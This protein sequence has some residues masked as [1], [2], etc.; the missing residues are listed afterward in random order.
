[1]SEKSK[2]WERL[3]P[4][5]R[6]IL[7]SRQKVV[8][9]KLSSI[10]KDFGLTVLS[11]TL[12]VGISGEIRPS[13]DIG[14]FVIKVN[15][16]DDARRQRFTVAHEMAHFLLH[17]DYIGNGLSD[18]ALYRSYLSDAKEAQANRLAADI[19]MPRNLIKSELARLGGEATES[20]VSRLADMFDVSV[21]AMQ[22][23]LDGM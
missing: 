18:D 17:R 12:P 3:T 9:V 13:T 6:T 2:E 16:H 14:S 15:R 5:V 23:R 20:T 21:A 22:I 10:A 11:A 19:L 4:E 8:P 7:E 1:M